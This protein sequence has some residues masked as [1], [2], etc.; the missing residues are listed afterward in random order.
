VPTPAAIERYTAAGA[1]PLTLHELHPEA[2]ADYFSQ[3]LAAVKAA[4]PSG[5]SVAQYT[6][7]EYAGMRAFLTPNRDAG[8]ALKEGDDIVSV[9]RHP[10]SPYTRATA[11]MLDLATQQGGARLDAFDTLLPHIYSRSGF[12]AISR[13]PFNP[14]FAPPDWNYEHYRPWNE[15]KPDV[16]FMAHNPKHGYLYRPGEGIFAPD[17]DQA[18]ALQKQAVKDIRGR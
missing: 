1:S 12:Q 7:E 14:E 10:Q 9:F 5:A 15:G 13:V 18:V 11:P 8:F 3:A 16:V 4:H 6:P 17:Y 2:G